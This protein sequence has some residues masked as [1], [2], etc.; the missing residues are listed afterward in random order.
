MKRLFDPKETNARVIAK[1]LRLNLSHPSPAYV[2]RTFVDTEDVANVVL[3]AVD[4]VGGLRDARGAYEKA[5]IVPRAGAFPASSTSEKIQLH[6]LPL[7]NI[8]TVRSMDLSPK[9]SLMV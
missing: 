8:I 5:L 3:K 4:K 2:R 7:D 6:V 1:E 9:T